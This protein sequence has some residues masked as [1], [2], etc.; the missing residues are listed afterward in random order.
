MVGMRDLLCPL[1]AQFFFA[2]ESHVEDLMDEDTKHWPVSDDL[3]LDFDQIKYDYR[4]TPLVVFEGK[5]FIGVNDVQN[6][7]KGA[8]VELHFQLHHFCI[9]PKKL[10]SFNAT[11]EQVLILQEGK[12]C[13][14][15]RYKCKNV[16]DGPMLLNPSLH[17]PKK[18]FGSPGHSPIQFAA[19][20]STSQLPFASDTVSVPSSSSTV[21]VVPS[22][23]NEDAVLDNSMVC[24]ASPPDR[25]KSDV[26]CMFFFLFCFLSESLFNIQS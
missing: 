19:V 3:R 12:A 4:T 21:L 18:V 26:T 9:W 15:S 25:S 6:K 8:V 1:Y 24:F 10:D 2:D 16:R 14:P 11:I 20:P 22:D 17:L 7:I 13:Q 23:N 5:T